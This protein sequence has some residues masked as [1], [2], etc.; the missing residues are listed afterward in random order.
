MVKKTAKAL[1]QEG[2][3]RVRLGFETGRASAI[4]ENARDEW[5]R[6]NTRRRESG[7]D[8]PTTRRLIHASPAPRISLAIRLRLTAC[9]CSTSSA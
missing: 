5:A 8:P 9:P 7:I 6:R 3:C 4:Q 1:E 2:S